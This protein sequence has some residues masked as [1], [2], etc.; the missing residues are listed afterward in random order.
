[1]VELAQKLAAIQNAQERLSDLPGLVTQVQTWQNEQQNTILDRLNAIDQSARAASTVINELGHER[2]VMIQS[3]RDRMDQTFV[4]SEER[5]HAADERTFQNN[6]EL[7]QVNSQA[8]LDRLQRQLDNANSRVVGSRARTQQAENRVEQLSQE[9]RARDQR[10]NMQE[11]HAELLQRQL[12]QEMESR[13]NSL[14]LY[15]ANARYPDIADQ[16]MRVNDRRI[17][18]L[19]RELR[20][21]ES[22]RLRIIA[23]ASD[24]APSSSRGRSAHSLPFGT[25]F[26]ALVQEQRAHDETRRAKHTA[27]LR[28]MQDL[29]RTDSLERTLSQLEEECT[30]SIGRDGGSEGELA[31]ANDKRPFYARLLDIIRGHDAGQRGITDDSDGPESGV[32]SYHSEGEGE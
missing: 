25:S 2:S 3:Q 21:S 15:E 16:A 13:S 24:L 32:G 29:Q 26:E 23:L 1:M 30:S 19:E 11:T 22:S 4:E 17:R 18:E 14:A 28:N 31:G 6:L 20:Q 10:L 7:H 27:E 9:I 8:H 12:E 5:R